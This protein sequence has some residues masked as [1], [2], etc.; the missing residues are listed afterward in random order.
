MST[1]EMIAHLK[2]MGLKQPQ[3]EKVLATYRDAGQFE[4]LEQ[5][6]EYVARSAAR[7]SWMAP[8]PPRNSYSA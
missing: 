6:H 8:A 1:Q 7:P 2:A 4:A 5:A 3:R